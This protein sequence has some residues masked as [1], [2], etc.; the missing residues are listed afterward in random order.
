MVF[1]QK[2]FYIFLIVCGLFFIRPAFVLADILGQSKIFFVEPTYD[3]QNKEQ[4][5]TILENI[6]KNAYF[7]LEKSFKTTLTIEELEQIELILKNLGQEFDQVIYPKLI[8]LYGVEWKNGID[9]DPKITVVFHQLKP[10]AAGYFRQ[11]D[12]YPKQQA[13]KSNEGEIIYLNADYLTSSYLKSFLAHEFTHLISFNQ[14]ERLKGIVEDVW[15]NEARAEFAPTLLDYDKDYE[16]SNLKQRVLQ[17]LQSPPDSLTDWE[18]QKKDYGSIAVFFQYLAEKYGSKIIVNTMEAPSAGFSSLNYSLEKWQ[19]GKTIEDIFTDWL[20]T[21][22]LNDCSLGDNYCFKAQGLTNLRVVPSL[23]FLSPQ[24]KKEFTTALSLKPWS[25]RW[26]RIL[27]T[28]GDLRVNLSAVLGVPFKLSYVLCNKENDC[29]VKF[30]EPNIDNKIEMFI[31]EFALKY[32]FLTVIPSIQPKTKTL[33][34]NQEEPFFELNLST[35]IENTKQDQDLIANL[36]AQILQLKAQIA[37]VQAQLQA[38]L[39]KKNTCLLT[40]NLFL[41]KQGEQVK[42]LQSFLVSQGKDIYPTAL[43]TGY[44]GPLT[45]EAV[46]RFQEKYRVEILTPLNFALGNGYVGSLTRAKINFLISQ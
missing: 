32:N 42:C 38:I 11:E 44:F 22:Y 8:S 3:S 15:L 20:V 23:I 6:S 5:E 18:S 4:I 26:Y 29:Q 7:Y 9:R 35:K 46:I 19:V 45:K 41:G 34:S 24:Q 39:A 27:T 30:L 33:T 13:Q 37:Q 16:K 12:E 28:E 43:I 10:G 14:K 40:Y 31:P 2:S 25:G 36:E 21:V 17:F 1:K